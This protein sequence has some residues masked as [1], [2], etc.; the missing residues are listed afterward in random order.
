MKERFS[1]FGLLLL[2]AAAGL[3]LMYHGWLKVTLGVENSANYIGKFGMPFD[4]APLA[5]AWLSVLAELLGGFFLL[6][7]L[8]T[9]YASF[10]LM[11][12]MSVAAF[13]ACAGLPIIAPNTPMTRELPLL[14]LTVV[15]T[16][17]I[18][19]AGR[20]SVDGSRGG[21]RSAPAKKA[22]TR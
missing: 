12:N 4:T 21:K 19:G 17:F 5:W 13:L 22:R 7:G 6:L 14:Y 15:S 3:G 2:R 9:R 10:A 1:D 20:F 11:I 16:I 8:W 18:I